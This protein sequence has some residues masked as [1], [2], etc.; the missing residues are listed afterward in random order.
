MKISSLGRSA[1]SK[2]GIK[3]RQPLDN[4]QISLNTKIEPNLIDRVTPQILD[5]LNVKNISV[6]DDLEPIVNFEVK[7]NLTILG[8]KYGADV[9]NIKKEILNHEPKSLYDLAVSNQ[10]INIGK[11]N[12]I[13]EDLLLNISPKDGYEIA[14]DDGYIVAISTEIST[15]MLKEGIARELVHRIQNMRR[16]A[17]FNISDKISIYYECDKGL[18]Q[19]INQF[20]NYICLE[21]LC[22]SLFDDK[23]TE[24]IYS[25]KFKLNDFNISIGIKINN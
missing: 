6:I 9:Q 12:L 15:E 13:S 8:P 5:E 11:Y 14:L 23:I 21:T 7:P 1:R 10:E 25:E 18:I 19:I 17:G 3:V 22:S 4:I 2:A 16:N 20:E 24:E